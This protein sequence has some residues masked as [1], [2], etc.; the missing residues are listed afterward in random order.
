[1]I[2]SS[3]LLTYVV[4]Y[5]IFDPE[6]LQLGSLKL[7]CALSSL[8]GEC[9]K[10]GL[11]EKKTGFLLQGPGYYHL[12]SGR[13]F[14]TPPHCLL[15]PS[16]SL[17]SLWHHTVIIPPLQTRPPSNWPPLSVLFTELCYHL[18]EWCQNP[19]SGFLFISKSYNFYFKNTSPTLHFYFQCHP[20][21]TVSCLYYISSL[22]SFSQ[23]L[24]LLSQQPILHT[25]A[26][27]LTK[28]LL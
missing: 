23:S 21:L 11:L 16:L 9:E 18:I 15:P 4:S 27:G 14:A 12:F 19:E 25:A 7:K 28:L 22:L 5:F 13:G 17:P 8:T 2:L 26:G 6:P 24:F 20:L 10:T 1:M 3:F